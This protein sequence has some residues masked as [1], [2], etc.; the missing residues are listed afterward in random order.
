MGAYSLVGDKEVVLTCLVFAK[1][2]VG[3][4]H[5]LLRE[6][7]RYIVAQRVYMLEDLR[8]NCKAVTL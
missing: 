6:E 8:L 4:K 5:K 2:K 3:L 7:L 1:A